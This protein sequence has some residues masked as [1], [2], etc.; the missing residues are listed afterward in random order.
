MTKV[1]EIDR[2]HVRTFMGNYSAY[3]EKKAMKRDDVMVH[4]AVSLL[5]DINV[6]DTA[7]L[8]SR[9]I[10]LFFPF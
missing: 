3:A 1:V 9:L 2:G 6:A 5:L 4:A 8:S 7:V 10:P